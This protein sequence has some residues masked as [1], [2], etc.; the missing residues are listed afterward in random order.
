[1]DLYEEIAKLRKIPSDMDY[2]ARREE[3]IKAVGE[4]AYLIVSHRVT[5]N[6]HNQLRELNNRT[7]PLNTEGTGP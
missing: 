1:M 7:G 5:E 4:K 3:L 6:L 2:L